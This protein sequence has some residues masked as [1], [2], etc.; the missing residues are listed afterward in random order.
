M[1][2]KSF[3]LLSVLL[4]VPSL[5]YSQTMPTGKLPP[6]SVP[7]SEGWVKPPMPA[8]P[9][10]PPSPV[11]PVSGRTSAPPAPAIIKPNPSVIIQPTPP[12]NGGFHP[13]ASG[14]TGG[15]PGNGSGGAPGTSTC[16]GGDNATITNNAQELAKTVA[17]ALGIV[18]GSPIDV[19][20]SEII[21]SSSIY[22]GGNHIVSTRFLSASAVLSALGVLNDPSNPDL[23]YLTSNTRYGFTAGTSY[24]L[25][26][27]DAGPSENTSPIATTW[28]DKSNGAISGFATIVGIAYKPFP[29]AAISAI[30]IK[31]QHGEIAS[32]KCTGSWSGAG[33]RVVTNILCAYVVDGVTKHSAFTGNV[34]GKATQTP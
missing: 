18:F 19:G 7:V 32:A 14:A 22:S 9:P 29:Y 1:K 10:V 8:S 25:Y 20:S 23:N 33:P 11:I 5:A 24:S 4:A 17:S 12:A 28:G 34:G 30:R 26:E 21:D 27:C 3:A 15:S 16:G 6:M 31:P 2:P 13:A